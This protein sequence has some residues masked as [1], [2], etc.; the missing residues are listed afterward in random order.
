[1]NELDFLQSCNKEQFVQFAKNFNV[2]KTKQEANYLLIKDKIIE[3]LS[4]HELTL[5]DI[6]PDIRKVTQ[7]TSTR[8]LK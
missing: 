3:L 1:M 4:T 8:I 5:N 6:M 2:F 7:Y